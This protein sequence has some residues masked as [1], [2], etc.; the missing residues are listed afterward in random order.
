M[1]SAVIVNYKMASFLPALVSSLKIEGVE[2][3]IV[4]DNPSTPD[5]REHV[6]ALDGVRTV[7]PEENRGYGAALNAGAKAARG[8][9]LLL[10]NPD[11]EAGP[12]AIAPLVEALRRYEAAGPNYLWDRAGRWHIPHPQP[13]TWR[14]DF[15][16]RARPRTA[17]RRALSYQLRRWTG[18]APVEAP[19]LSGAAFLIRRQAFETVG[20]FDE[21]FFLYFEENDFFVRFRKA[22]FRAAVAPRARFFHFHEPGRDPGQDERYRFSKELYERTWFPGLYRSGR[23]LL[24]THT[25]PPA[26]RLDWDAPLRARGRTVLFALSPHLIPCAAAFGVQG[27]PTARELLAGTPARGGFLALAEGNAVRARWALGVQ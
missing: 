26:P 21:R 17:L 24:G 3:I 18:T 11:M 8:D 1:L 22:G 14:S 10:L 12:G 16:A 27:T 25:P 20:G 2:E 6:T 19:L 5:E 9:A 4:A 13:H 7:L 23:R 15:T